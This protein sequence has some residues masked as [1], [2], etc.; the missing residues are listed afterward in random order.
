MH[1]DSHKWVRDTRDVM[2]QHH[3][4]FLSQHPTAANFPSFT[5]LFLLENFCLFL[6]SNATDVKAKPQDSQKYK[7]N[8]YKTPNKLILFRGALHVDR[9]PL[10]QLRQE[11]VSSFSPF[12]FLFDWLCFCLFRPAWLDL[13]SPQHREM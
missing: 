1:T 11:D 5:Y 10:F 12:G 8:D 7:L 3:F 6:S 2:Q 13:V 9:H 4:C